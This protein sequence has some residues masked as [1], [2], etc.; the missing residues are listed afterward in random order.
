LLALGLV[1]GLIAVATVAGHVNDVRNRMRPNPAGPCQ[2][3]P[4]EGASGVNIPGTN[5]YVMP[6]V[7]GGTATISFP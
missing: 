6:C 1:I 3:G 4:E 5:K 2:G 7:F